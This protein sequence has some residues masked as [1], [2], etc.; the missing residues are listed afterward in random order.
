MRKLVLGA[1][2]SGDA[3]GVRVPRAAGFRGHGG[4]CRGGGREG[5]GVGVGE[6]EIGCVK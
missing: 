5:T 4:F 3:G 1:L 6:G 2:R